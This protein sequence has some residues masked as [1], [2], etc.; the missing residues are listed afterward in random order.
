M[1]SRAVVK[2]NIGAEIRRMADKGAKLFEIRKQI[3]WA[4]SVYAKDAGMKKF[5]DEL[6]MQYVIKRLGG[7]P[8]GK[9]SAR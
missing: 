4:R 1:T 5:L 6:E 9:A 2:Q 8:Y 7:L 3:D